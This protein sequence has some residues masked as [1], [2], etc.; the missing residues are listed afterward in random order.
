MGRCGW[1]VDAAAGRRPALSKH[2]MACRRVDFPVT[3]GPLHVHVLTDLLAYAIGFQIF[4]RARTGDTFTGND[5]IIL[6]A[7]TLVG[8]LVGAKLLAWLIDPA[9]TWAAR[10]DPSIW[11]GGK[12][13]VGALLGGLVA[14]ESFKVWRGIRGSTG[15]LYAMP[16]L[17]GIAIGRVGCQLSGR[18]DRTYGSPTGLPWAI[19]LGDGVLRHPLPL[20]EILA[21]ALIATL[22]LRQ[23]HLADGRVPDGD[24]FR[25]FL[26]GYMVWRFL[27]G[28]LQPLPTWAGLSAIQWASVLYLAV[29]ARHV[30]RLVSQ[31][32]AAR[33][34]PPGAKSDA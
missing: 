17:V 8:A 25:L 6:A 9:A 26:Y 34:S 24:R 3:F 4:R 31:L 10:T 27:G 5:R 7:V 20:Y 32:T 15:D 28:F 1:R 12:T 29:Y 2:W 23:T 16:L 14:V 22:M 19:D 18:E 21:L 33:P 11:I 13:I 30:P